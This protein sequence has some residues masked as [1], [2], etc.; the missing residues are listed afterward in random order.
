MGGQPDPREIRDAIRAKYQQAALSAEGLFEYA[1]GAVALGYDAAIIA[2]APRP[3]LR[4]FCGVGNP[5]ALGEIGEDETVLDIGCGAGL[6]LYVTNRLVGKTGL[7]LGVDLTPEMASI[8][9]GLRG[10]ERI[11]RRCS[12]VPGSDRS[13]YRLVM[14]PRDERTLVLPP[15]PPPQLESR[16]DR[17]GDTLR[18]ESGRHRADGSYRNLRRGPDGHGASRDE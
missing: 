5:F 13:E 10:I 4:S 12:A 15:A 7:T 8:A 3:V 17:R 6:D 2:D 14:S 16:H 11:G 9:T 1:A 18:Q